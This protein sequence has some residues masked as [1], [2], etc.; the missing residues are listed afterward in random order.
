MPLYPRLRAHP[1]LAALGLALV[2]ALAA[3]AGTVWLVKGDE[4]RLGRSFSWVLSRYLDRPVRV[5]LVKTDGRTYIEL[6]GIRVPPAGE[7][8]SD[9]R[10]QQ[11]RL[12]G[13]FI[14][15]ALFPQ[16]RH[17][18]V[19]V[20]S[21]TLVMAPRTEPF[22]L[23]AKPTLETAWSAVRWLLEWPAG[24]TFSL[25]GGELRS[26]G[27]TAHFDLTGEKTPEGQA[28]FT[29]TARGSSPATSL[30]L[31]GT[32][33]VS[34]DTLA[35]RLSAEGDPRALGPLWPEALS[36]VT[37][38]DALA[39]LRVPGSELLDLAGE[40]TLRLDAAATPVA[41]TLSASYYP[42]SAQADIS[43]LTVAWGDVL[44]LQASGQA[45]ALSDSPRLSLRVAGTIEGSPVLASLRV[46][47]ADKKL[48]SVVQ[49]SQPDLQ[50]WLR[51]FGHPQGLARD[52]VV[53]AAGA[54]L[55]ADVTW[56][57]EGEVEWS[58]IRAQLDRVALTRDGLALSAPVLRVIATVAPGGEGDELIAEG[59]LF[60]QPLEIQAFGLREQ[61]AARADAQIR[62]DRKRPWSG[63]RSLQRAGGALST[64]E[65]EAIVQA[66]FR[67]PEALELLVP[68]LDRLPQM[69]P[70]LTYSLRGSARVSGRL[71]WP[72]EG[73]HFRGEAHL[74]MPR[75]TLRELGAEIANVSASLPVGYGEDG[76]LNPGTVTIESLRV[77]GVAFDGFRASA[78]LRNGFLDLPE[79][80]YVHYGGRGTGWVQAELANPDLPIRFRFE[81]DGV[82]LS[83]FVAEYGLKAARVSGRARYVVGLIHTR[84]QGAEAAGRLWVDD[85]GGVVSIDVLKSLLSHAPEGPLGLIRDTLEGLSEFPYSSLTGEISM[86]QGETRIDLNLQGRKRFGIFPPRIQAITIQNL[87]LSFV[88][89]VL[90]PQRRDR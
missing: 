58:R 73:P 42:A 57:P 59:W 81:A 45:E 38:L 82:D 54:Q 86:A 35:L 66:T 49:L 88:V 12:E 6:R 17:L 28:L 65:G 52:L 79:A 67:S 14:P 10:A 16:G 75:A 37:R 23:P 62:L 71:R 8:T 78:Q 51:R 53:R 11:V 77:H 72:A 80:T 83:Q 2:V 24:A 64:P 44:T 3:L 29:L 41:L 9:L 20:V 87:P 30:T 84:K 26:E 89:K 55:A 76:S 68:R 56:S 5:D 15:L 43:R 32:G 90:S 18:S 25:Q 21:T 48:Q 74:E 36:P 33:N 69:V 1:L 63:I 47:P 31:K 19:Q 70:G 61:M 40:A 22:S 7:W 85:P 27:R 34:A 39:T 60:A 46:S 4:A 13:A 50:R